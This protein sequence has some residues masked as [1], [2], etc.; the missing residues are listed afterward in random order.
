MD[1][2]EVTNASEQLTAVGVA[3]PNARDVLRAAVADVPELGALQ[4]VD[5]S[6]AGARVTAARGDNQSVAGTISISSAGS[7]IRCRSR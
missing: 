5:L 7:A 1:D 4:F 3:G 2:V 6:W